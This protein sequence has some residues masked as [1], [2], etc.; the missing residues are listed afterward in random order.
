MKPTCWQVLPK[1]QRNVNFLSLRNLA[2]NE[3]FFTTFINLSL[4][5]RY[6]SF[7]AY[8][9]KVENFNIKNAKYDLENYTL[10]LGDNRT[11][12]NEFLEEDIEVEF[13]KGKILVIFSKD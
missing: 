13:T 6:I 10:Y 4:S 8:C 11:V 9:D 3:L 5:Y 7:L 12:S 1:L 2:S